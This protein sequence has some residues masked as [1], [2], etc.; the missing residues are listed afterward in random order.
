MRNAQVRCAELQ[1]M[2]LQHRQQERRAIRCSTMT[3][4]RSNRAHSKKKHTSQFQAALPAQR[5]SCAARCSAKSA[6]RPP[7]NESMYPLPG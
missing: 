7:S 6:M 5:T 4:Q 2:W 1:D 3:P